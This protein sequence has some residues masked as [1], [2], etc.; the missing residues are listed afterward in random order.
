[1]LEGTP[2]ISSV[3]SILHSNVGGQMLISS[4]LNSLHPTSN[5]LNLKQS[6]LRYTDIKFK[7]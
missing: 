4:A 5:Y 6:I 3:F 2:L 7:A 1:M